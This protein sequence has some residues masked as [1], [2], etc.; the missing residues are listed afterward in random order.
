MEAPEFQLGLALS[1]GGFR[2]MLFHLGSLWRI[3][4]LGLLKRLNVIT[5]VSGGSI[6]SGALAAAWGD[7]NFVQSNG[8]MTDVAQNF[9]KELIDPVWEFC[10]RN[11]DVRSFLEGV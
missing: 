11:L 3:N 1:G 8:G 5:S 10:N 4:D 6:I 2:A 7:L 9:R